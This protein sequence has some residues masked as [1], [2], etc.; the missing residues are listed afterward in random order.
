MLKRVKLKSVNKFVIAFLAIAIAMSVSAS[1][2][3]TKVNIQAMNPWS[4]CAACAG[5]GGAGPSAS[6]GTASGVASPSLTGNA[7]IFQ[8]AS[9]YAYADALWW[10]QLGAVNTAHNLVYDV[11]FY[12]KNP[13]AAQALEF[14]SNQANGRVRF[15]F[16]TECS[17]GSGQWDV[18]GN[19]NGN[20]IH[21]G[22]PC[23]MPKAY[24][25]HHLTWEFKRNE[26]QLEFVAMT[27][28]GVKHYVNRTYWGRPSGVSEL[29]V[30]FQMDQR[31]NHVTYQTWL[32][33][34]SLKYW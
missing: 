13:A 25:W 4:S 5:A 1:A 18:W 7:R 22:I 26:Q 19:A 30:A 20:W 17:L 24:T 10:K 6:L 9:N 23:T 2:Q 11:W 16:G 27:L 3:V 12:I 21:T 8:I 32:D 33:K 34:V 15:I 29:N 14:D 28:D 31:A